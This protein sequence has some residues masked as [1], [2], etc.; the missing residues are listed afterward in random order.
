MVMERE[1]T[2]RE[3]V[4]QHYPYQKCSNCPVQITRSDSTCKTEAQKK[5]RNTHCAGTD[6]CSCR[7]AS[8]L[9]KNRCNKSCFGVIKC[10]LV[11]LSV[12]HTKKI[13]VFLALDQTFGPGAPAPKTGPAGV[14]FF[15]PLPRRR[16]RPAGSCIPTLHSN[17]PN[18]RPVRS[19]PSWF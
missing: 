7:L 14:G 2:K 3:V 12:I 19:W 15:R 1:N 16:Y 9:H 6:S 17:W 13:L 5:K 18:P 4:K 10:Y 8:E 11:M